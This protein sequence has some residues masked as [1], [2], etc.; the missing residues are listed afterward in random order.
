M[1]TIKDRLNLFLKEHGISQ[2]RFAE[3]VHVSRGYVNAIVDGIK[4]PVLERMKRAYPS[5]SLEWLICG[6]GQMLL[7]GE[8]GSAPETVPVIPDG[9]YRDG[10]ADIMSAVKTD[11]CRRMAKIPQLSATD[12]YAV[13]Q[14]D[15][16]RPRFEAGDLVACRCVPVG[17][18][19]INGSSYLLTI[20]G[21]G[22][23]IRRLYDTGDSYECR[24]FNQEYSPFSVPKENVSM[25]AAVIGLLRTN[26]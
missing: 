13:V 17:T 19:C 7:S 26:V 20:R 9:L 14:T 5:L 16:M 23:I 24:S 22:T 4:S 2:Q 3:A 8:A 1:E 6:T 15:A 18:T 11:A 25:M 10:E 21:A 12:L